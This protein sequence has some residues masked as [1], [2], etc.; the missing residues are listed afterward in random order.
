[1]KME[2]FLVKKAS[3]VT[4][5]VKVVAASSSDFCRCMWYQPKEPDGLE[6]F[7]KRRKKFEKKDI[8][9]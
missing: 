9:E 6:E 1:M 3:I 2:R 5:L 8:L 4:A 7:A